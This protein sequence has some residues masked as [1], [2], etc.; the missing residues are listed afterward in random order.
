MFNIID[1][2]T[3]YNNK[4]VIVSYV[5]YIVKSIIILLCDL[6]DTQRMILYDFTLFIGGIKEFTLITFIL[7]LNWNITNRLI[8]IIAK[9]NESDIYWTKLFDILFNIIDSNELNIKMHHDH[10]VKRLQFYC[11]IRKIIS[12]LFIILSS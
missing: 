12:K 4:L 11:K 5:I 9:H 8:H 2:I 7:G 3:Q 10:I 6:S 1:Y